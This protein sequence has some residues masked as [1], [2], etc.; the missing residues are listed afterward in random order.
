MN[1]PSQKC[2]EFRSFSFMNTNICQLFVYDLSSAALCLFSSF[3]SGTAVLK[4]FIRL[5]PINK[6]SFSLIHWGC[7]RPLA[8]LKGQIIS[9]CLFGVFNFFQKTYENKSTS[10]KVEFICSFFGRNMG[11]KKSF[12]IC[13]TFRR[14]HD[15]ESA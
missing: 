15:F 9:K 13:L 5:L 12:R 3:E 14:V 1:K 6:N 4:F 7:C 10:S 11:F 2:Y 8:L